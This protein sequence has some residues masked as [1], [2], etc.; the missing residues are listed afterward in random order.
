MMRT[1]AWLPLLLLAANALPAAAQS[2]SRF[3]R[4]LRGWDQDD[5]G[6]LTEEETSERGWRYLRGAAEKYGMKTKDRYKIRDVLKARERDREDRKDEGEKKGSDSEKAAGFDTKTDPPRVAGFG[7]GGGSTDGDS[8]KQDDEDRDDDGRRDRARRD[9]RRLLDRYDRNDNRLLERDEWRRISGSPEKADANGDG[10]IT[11][12]ELTN[13]LES[14][15]RRRADED[16][17]ERRSSSSASSSSASGSRSAAAKRS[18]D[19]DKRRS[20]RFTPAHERLPSGL[21]SWFRERDRDLDG[22]VAMHEYSSNW[23]E[24]RVREFAKYDKN[25]DGVINASEVLD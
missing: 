10:T 21:P 15:Y 18:A 13:R 20:Y 23:T 14:N 9:A 3:E 24:S 22:Q 11:L 16:R 6:Y 8:R 12:D 5:D 2:S 17:R 7:E 19:D 25:G 4:M 1:I